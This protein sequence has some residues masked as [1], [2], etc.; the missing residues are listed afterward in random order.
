MQNQLSLPYFDPPRFTVV[1]VMHNL[2]LGTGK[3]V[4]KLWLSLELLELER[5]IRT[6]IVPHSVGRLPINIMSSLSM[7]V[8]DHI[9]LCSCFGRTSSRRVLSALACVCSEEL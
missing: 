9:L 5:K 1:D 7:A 2:F 8:L 3:R 4:F 6:F